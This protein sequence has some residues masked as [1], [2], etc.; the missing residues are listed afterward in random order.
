[1]NSQLAEA[2]HVYRMTTD[3]RD[4]LLNT[5][6]NEDLAFEIPGNPMLGLL[7]AEHAGVVRSY[8]E[9]FKTYRQDWSAVATDASLAVSIDTLKAA[10]KALDDELADV[11]ETI[12]DEDFK[13]KQI[14]RGGYS[15]SPGAQLHTLR[16]GLLIIMGKAMVYMRAMGKPVPQRFSD[17]IG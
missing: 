9:S 1:M 2:H 13:T 8:I 10:F 11:L 12:S 14:D 16:E 6:S 3:V 17:W 15:F 4:L 5:L 7:L